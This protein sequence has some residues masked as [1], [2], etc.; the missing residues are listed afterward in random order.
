MGASLLDICIFFD[1][2]RHI[3]RNTGWWLLAPSL[4]IKRSQLIP[5]FDASNSVL[6]LAIILFTFATSH[7]LTGHV[8]D[9]V[10]QRPKQEATWPRAPSLLAISTDEVHWSVAVYLIANALTTLAPPRKRSRRSRQDVG[11]LFIDSQYVLLSQAGITQRE[12]REMEH[13]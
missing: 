1:D 12:I 5:Y 2:K 4:L 6:L 8:I 10:N 7:S 9:R 13:L 11:R 3:A